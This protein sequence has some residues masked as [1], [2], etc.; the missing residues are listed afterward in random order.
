MRPLGTRAEPTRRLTY[1]SAVEGLAERGRLTAG[2]WPRRSESIQVD[3]AGAGP[4]EAAVLDS[5]ARLLHLAP[6]DRVWLGAETSSSRAA[7]AALTV[8]VVGVFRPLPRAG[9]ER[10]P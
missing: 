7:G 3:G 1:L 8:T 6:G 10:D 5:T 2:R 4:L 9:W